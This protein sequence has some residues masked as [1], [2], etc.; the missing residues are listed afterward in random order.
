[1]DNQALPQ[2]SAHSRSSACLPPGD[3]EIAWEEAAIR[4]S[5]DNLVQALC[6]GVTWGPPS[7]PSVISGQPGY[8]VRTHEFV[9]ILTYDELRRVMLHSLTP[10]EYFAL[11]ERYGLFSDID[12]RFYCT[13]TGA[14]VM[15]VVTPPVAMSQ[16]AEP[17]ESGITIQVSS[18]G[19][20]VRVLSNGNVLLD[21]H[22]VGPRGLAD[23]LASLGHKVTLEE[24]SPEDF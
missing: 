2:D 18:L 8:R 24:R 15:P 5:R 6:Q 11:V 9:F 16:Q 3:I 22:T 20:W 1:M 14:A 4:T 13:D 10:P 21:G 12:E 19:D 7:R 17:A 23:C